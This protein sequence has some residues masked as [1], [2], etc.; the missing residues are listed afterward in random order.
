MK[1][2]LILLILSIT[3]C[4]SP[5]AVH[6]QGNNSA[7]IATT[8]VAA[9]AVGITTASAVNIAIESIEL[10]AAEYV[11]KNYPNQKEFSVKLNNPFTGTD[12]MSDESPSYFYTFNLIFGNPESKDSERLLLMQVVHP[13]FIN[14][15]GTKETYTRWSVF[16]GSEWNQL[17]EAYANLAFGEVIVKNGICPR[18]KKERRISNYDSLDLTHYLIRDYTFSDLYILDSTLTYK[19][20]GLDVFSK[21]LEFSDPNGMKPSILIL[22]FSKISGD[23]YFQTPYNEDFSLVYNEKALGFFF[24]REERMFQIKNSI[25]ND[26]NRFLN[27]RK[28]SYQGL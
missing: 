17:F 15:F 21:G 13:D 8:A 9:L 14:E 25:V 1:K 27:Y 19:L 10:G 23:S 2:K 3:L 12:K 24:K 26:I 16:N 5:K 28:K 7:I 6:S 20:S 11:L 22:P 18:L 4:F